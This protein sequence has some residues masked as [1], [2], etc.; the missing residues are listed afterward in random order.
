MVNEYLESM[1]DDMQSALDALE[2][3]LTTVAPVGPL[4]SFSKMFRSM[5]RLMGQSYLSI[6]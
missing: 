3:E 4:P 5:L 1:N 6:G 2:K